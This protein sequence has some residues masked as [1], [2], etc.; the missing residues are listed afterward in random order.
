ML[1]LFLFVSNRGDVILHT[2]LVP[3]FLHHLTQMGAA[4]P[5]Y[6]HSYIVYQLNFNLEIL[7]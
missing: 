1:L 7:K 2:A 3:V 5:L 6:E 4:V